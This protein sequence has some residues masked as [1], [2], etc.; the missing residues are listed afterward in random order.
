ML[1]STQKT[2][3]VNISSY[4]TSKNVRIAGVEMN[5]RQAL[6]NHEFVMSP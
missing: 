3:N 5:H 6:E 2:P 1:K 4:A